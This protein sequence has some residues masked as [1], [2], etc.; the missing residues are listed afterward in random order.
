MF[1][2]L[3]A[4]SLFSHLRVEFVSSTIAP[5]GACFLLWTKNLCF[6]LRESK[7]NTVPSTAFWKI[8][9]LEFHN[10]SW[11]NK[12]KALSGKKKKKSIIW[13]LRQ[14]YNMQVEV[15]NHGLQTFSWKHMCFL[16]LSRQELA[17]CPSFA[18]LPM[19][20]LEKK[21]INITISPILAMKSQFRLLQLMCESVWGKKHTFTKVPVTL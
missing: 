13:Q 12:A 5:C 14:P 11:R 3:L 9:M 21:R 7:F 16:L 18:E 10:Y 17:H 15:K 2:S 19:S 4:I 20:F 8:Q 1:V 6:S